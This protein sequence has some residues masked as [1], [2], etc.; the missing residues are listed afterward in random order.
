M[1]S[2]VKIPGL[3]T[4]KKGTVV[5]ITIGG[6]A[7]AG[8]LIY[9][10]QKKSKAAAAASAA[11]ASTGYG[12]GAS[13]GYGYGVMPNGYYGYGEPGIGPYGYGASG[14]F[15]AGYYGYGVPLQGS[16]ANTT[17]AQW[18]QA[19]INQLTSEG[20]DAQTVSA[21]LG[22]YLAGQAVTAAQQTIVQAAIGIEGY[23]PQSPPPLTVQGTGGGGTG[24][25]QT[26]GGGGVTGGNT[27]KVP[28]IVGMSVNDGIAALNKVGLK[29]HLSSV[30]NPISTYKI[31]SIT[32]GAGTMVAPGSTVRV[33]IVKT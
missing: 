5:G 22:A 31:N 32:P 25:G 24:G 12:Y 18:A 6:F 23:P 11:A 8:F 15:N 10:E 14:G 26:G 7:V 20:Y 4:Q 17:N 3:G 27:V 2:T 28:S 19:A 13:S 16:V 29:N 21:A 30:R 1:A 9:K 33:G